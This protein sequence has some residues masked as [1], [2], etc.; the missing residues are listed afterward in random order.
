M[1]EWLYCPKCGTK[2]DPTDSACRACGAATRSATTVPSGEQA[3]P[4]DDA[5]LR[6]LTAELRDALAPNIQVLRPLGQGGMGTVFLARDP[7]LKRLVV[8]KVLSPQLAHDE[9]ARKR[10]AREAESAAA[11]SHPN[12]VKIYQVGELPALGTSY[13]VME[14]VDGPTLDEEFP[15]GTAAPEAR[16]KRIIGEVASALTAG[17]RAA[18]CIATSNPATSCSTGRRIAWWC[19]TSASARR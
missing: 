1:S 13:F 2:L 16:V 9:N 6:A 17:T 8:V 7:A 12:V 3:A 11:V 4:S 15:E 5:E 14:H 18:L 10:F 19:S